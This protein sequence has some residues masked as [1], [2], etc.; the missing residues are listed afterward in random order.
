VHPGDPS[1]VGVIAHF[2]GVARD[3]N[4]ELKDPGQGWLMAVK[5]S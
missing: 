2:D 4:P 1:A 3:E 5:P